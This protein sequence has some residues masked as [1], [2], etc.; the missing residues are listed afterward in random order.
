[1]RVDEDGEFWNYVI[2]GIV[3]CVVG[4]GVAALSSYLSDGKVDVESVIINAAV[5]GISGIVAASGL[6]ALTQAGITALVSGIGNYADQFQ[7]KGIENVN[8]GEVVASAALGGITSLAGTYMGKICG[9]KWVDEAQ[10]LTDVGRS[11][12]LTGVVRRS[13]GQSHSALMRQGNKYL[14]MATVPTNIS[15]GISSVV[16]TAISGSTAFLFNTTKSLW[17][18]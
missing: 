9:A 12:L 14:A 6:N 18:W 7:S 5:G 11:K 2:G 3:G 17:G 15:R 13:L 10:E 16:G 1:M 4:G 8:Y